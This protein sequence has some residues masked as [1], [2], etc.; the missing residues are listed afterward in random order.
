MKN[1]IVLKC[2]K[3]KKSSLV[4]FPMQYDFG[5]VC[6]LLYPKSI[7]AMIWFDQKRDFV[8]RTYDWLDQL[9]GRGFDLHYQSKLL[10]L[11]EI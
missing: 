2:K 6:R 3:A 11:L 5:V 7:V 10:N 4:Y 8:A 1:E 9:I